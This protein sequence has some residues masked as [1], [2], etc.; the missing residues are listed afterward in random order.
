MKFGELAIAL[1]SLSLMWALVVL[2]LVQVEGILHEPILKA[3]GLIGLEASRPTEPIMG[4]LDP[5]GVKVSQTNGMDSSV[6]CFH[7][8]VTYAVSKFFLEW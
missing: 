2:L 6:N 7:G 5:T 4:R 3:Q 1:S 8:F